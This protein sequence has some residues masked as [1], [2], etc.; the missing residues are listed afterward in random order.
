MTLGLERS[1]SL[2]S[3]PQ[4]V[5]TFSWGTFPAAMRNRRSFPRGDPA[6]WQGG[7]GGMGNGERRRLKATLLVPR[8]EWIG[9]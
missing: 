8:L 6:T 5:N 1:S 9:S 3:L 4:V 2:A 7:A